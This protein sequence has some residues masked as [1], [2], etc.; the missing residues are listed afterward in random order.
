MPRW[1]VSSLSLKASDCAESCKWDCESFHL[2][3][4]LPSPPSWWKFPAITRPFTANVFGVR[5]LKALSS[6]CRWQRL[7]RLF[8]LPVS[9]VMNFKCGGLNTNEEIDK[10]SYIIVC[11]LARLQQCVSTG[12]TCSSWWI[13][14]ICIQWWKVFKCIFS[15]MYC[16]LL[17]NFDTCTL[18][19]FEYFTQHFYTD[20]FQG[21]ILSVLLHLLE[22]VVISFS[23]T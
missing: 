1:R 2:R 19:E 7:A 20:T 8:T 21:E 23:E 9:A 5:A 10:Q 14:Y 18:I 12:A 11:V 3:A 22:V 13:L 4:Q 6:Y 17:Y 15:N 16:V